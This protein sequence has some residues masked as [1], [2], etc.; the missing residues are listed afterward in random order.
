MKLTN[1]VT[2]TRKAF[3][4]ELITKLLAA[5][6]PI[7]SACFAQTGPAAAPA[8]NSLPVPVI[9]YSYFGETGFCYDYFGKVPCSTTGFGIRIGGSNA[10]VVTDIDTPIGSAATGVT[11]STL[12]PA[13][14][15]VVALNGHFSFTAIGATGVTSNGSNAG[16][17]F[18]GGA[19]LQYDLGYLLSKGKFSLLMDF[20]TRI[21]AAPNAPANA[22]KPVY[23]LMFRKTF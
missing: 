8:S 18:G 5:A 15:W 17:S 6:L 23:G 21:M 3:K 1:A 22:V 13:L 10:F 4:A 20:Q 9:G 19:G 14:E 7:S 12:R 11:Y 2:F 16:V